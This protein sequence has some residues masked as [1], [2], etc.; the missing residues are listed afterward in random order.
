MTSEKN[1]DNF[2]RHM[3]T[4]KQFLK[5]LRFPNVQIA[6]VAMRTI[7]LQSRTHKKVLIIVATGLS[8]QEDM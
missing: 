4:L 2:L 6:I 7:R 3:Y 8:T 1:A 5:F